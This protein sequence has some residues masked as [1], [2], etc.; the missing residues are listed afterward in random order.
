LEHDGRR[1]T[2]CGV[3]LRYLT[4]IDRTGFPNIK[5]WAARIAAPPGW[6]HPY[7][8]MKRGFPRG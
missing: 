2:Q 5:A 8:L 1:L 3:I 7:Y 6:A 4:G